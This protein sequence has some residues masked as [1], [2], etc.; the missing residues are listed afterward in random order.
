ML[1]KECVDA[2]QNQYELKRFAGAYVEDCKRLTVDEIKV[3]L[4]KTE[5]QYLSLENITQ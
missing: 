1:F 5:G 4:A 2:S 3:A